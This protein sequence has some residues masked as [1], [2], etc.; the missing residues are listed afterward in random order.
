MT[1]CKGGYLLPPVIKHGYYESLC[2]LTFNEISLA[3]F[4]VSMLALA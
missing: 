1:F 2:I 3:S 4:V